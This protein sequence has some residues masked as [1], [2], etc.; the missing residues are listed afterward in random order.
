ML[1]FHPELVLLDYFAGSL[2]QE[3]EVPVDSAFGTGLLL[4]DCSDNSAVGVEGTTFE[5]T[6]AEVGAGSVG[7]AEVGCL[8]NEGDSCSQAKVH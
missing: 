7:T 8:R 6:A 2:G 1:Y 3:D 5:T 4:T